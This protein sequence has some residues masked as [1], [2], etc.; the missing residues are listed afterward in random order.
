MA[1]FALI[2]PSNQVDRFGPATAP[3]KT[4]WRWLPCPPV[5]QPTPFDPAT[6]VI[7][8][9]TYTVNAN[10]VTEVWTK[11]NLTA[12]E[13]SDRKDVAVNGIN[14]TTYAPLQRLL[15]NMNNRIRALE[16]QAALTAPQ[17]KA[18]IKTLLP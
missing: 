8:G 15:F 5:A 9:P 2:N 10:D 7:E 4:G 1:R 17:F 3:T 18:F 14:G 16:G 13:I 11:R 6:E 12:Q